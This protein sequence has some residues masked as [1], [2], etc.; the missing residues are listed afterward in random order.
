MY[1]KKKNESY[2]LFDTLA[3][4]VVP[5]KYPG[6]VGLARIVEHC[7]EGLIIIINF[8]LRAETLELGGKL[9]EEVFI[10]QPGNKPL[11]VA[12]TLLDLTDSVRLSSLLLH[13]VERIERLFDR[14]AW[15]NH[16]R[17]LR[18]VESQNNLSLKQPGW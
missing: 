2:L 9:L 14:D 7:K 5:F 12:A 18:G 11:G 3:H 1:D 4:N 10:R 16:F 8:I 13:L 6:E 17:V 15:R